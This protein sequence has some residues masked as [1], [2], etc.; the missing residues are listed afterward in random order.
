M[1]HVERKCS[2]SAKADTEE[3]DMPPGSDF[4]SGLNR[5]CILLLGDDDTGKT[6]HAI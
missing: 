6:S 3:I 5:Y 1:E 4:L 2:E